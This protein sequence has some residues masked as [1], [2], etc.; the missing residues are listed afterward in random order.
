MVALA[1]RL[2]SAASPE[3]ALVLAAAALVHGWQALHLPH[4]QT[5]GCHSGCPQPGPV[6]VSGMVGAWGDH[7]P[8][9]SWQHLPG[10]NGATVTSLLTASY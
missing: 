4:Y 10:T 1:Q 7:P 3:V 5:A 2:V 8:P 6:P 9:S